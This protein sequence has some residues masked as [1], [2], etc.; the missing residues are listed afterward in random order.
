MSR[1]LQVPLSELAHEIVRPIALQTGMPYRSVGVKWYGE[2]VHIHEI[3]NGHEFDASRFEIRAN[4]LIY[5]DMW[6]RRGSVA[7]VPE[8]L[9][10]CVASSHFPTFELDC[11]RVEP[12]YLAWYFRT[13]TFW[14][15]CETASRGSTGRNQ[16]KRKAFLAIRAPLPPLLDQRRMIARIDELATQIQEARA[17]RR[18]ATGQATVLLM[19]GAAAIFDRAV[20]K[21]PIYRLEELVQIRGGGTPTKSNPFYWQ[22]SVPWITPKDMKERS[23]S[24]AIDHISAAATEETA[25]KLIEA[26][27]VLVVVRGMILAHTFPSA[28]LLVPAAINQD[29][30]A[31]IPRNGLLPEFL[32]AMFWAYNRRILDLVEKSTHDTRKL[33]TAK[34]LDTKIC[35]PPLREQRRIVVELGELQEEVEG[36]TSLQTDTAAGLDALLPAILDHAFKGEL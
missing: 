13:P 12:C 35:V 23:L 7:I 29:M 2:G 15:A 26:G 20:E 18:Q 4:D 36:L 22:G 8:D 21:Y 24:D 27:A 1:I 31:L 25:A 11:S 10:G 30:K 9:S 5:N 14:D 3:R 16:I 33:E 32:C 17:L 28:V 34:L 19:Q 6:A